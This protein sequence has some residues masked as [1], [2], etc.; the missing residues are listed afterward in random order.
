LE[1]ICLLLSFIYGFYTTRVWKEFGNIKFFDDV[2]L[3][4]KT[5]IQKENLGITFEEM[6]S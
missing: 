3:M 1:F 5:Q 4:L 6:H 2:I